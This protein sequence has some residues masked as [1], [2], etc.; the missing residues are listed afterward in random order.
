MIFFL[1][2]FFCVFVLLGLPM[3]MEVM[4]VSF[5]VRWFCFLDVL[6]LKCMGKCKYVL[7]GITGGLLIFNLI[8]MYY[9]MTIF[10]GRIECLNGS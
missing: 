5:D 8:C 10:P 6:I 4:Y 3:L 2:V 7:V 9:F 1:I